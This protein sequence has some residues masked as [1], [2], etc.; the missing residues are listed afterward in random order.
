MSDADEVRVEP[1]VKE[2]EKKNRQ[3]LLERQFVMKVKGDYT[4]YYDKNKPDKVAIREYKDCIVGVDKDNNIAIKAIVERVQEKGWTSIKISGNKALQIAL[5]AEAMDKGIIVQGYEKPKKSQPEKEV[6]PEEVK[7]EKE[8]EIEVKPGEELEKESQSVAED[9][10][11]S[12][13]E[14]VSESAQ[15]EKAEEKTE[16]FAPETHII[17]P[18]SAAQ[19]KFDLDVTRAKELRENRLGATTSRLDNPTLEEVGARE[20]AYNYASREKALMAYPELAPVYDIIAETQGY[21]EDNRE[22]YNNET[23]QGFIDAAR[24]R[25]FTALNKGDDLQKRL[26]QVR[27]QRK[28]EREVETPVEG[29]GA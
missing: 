19:K 4:L 12:T 16:E 1:L 9:D 11:E 25:C 23:A 8:S 18:D 27:G 24:D 28:A 2:K 10:P 3:S 20:Y 6:Q 13:D 14:K 17:E 26:D 5:A 15:K 21:L 29:L 22:K 7:P